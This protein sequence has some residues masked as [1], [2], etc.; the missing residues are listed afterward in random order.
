MSGVR[1]G[2][3]QA[4]VL[5]EV[6][7]PARHGG[8]ELLGELGHLGE[9][10]GELPLADHLD[11]DRGL[12][13]DGRGA[14]TVVEEGDLTDVGA[15]APLGDDPPAL[16]DLDLTVEHD[17]ELVPGLALLGEHGARRLLEVGGQL[18]DQ[19]EL[20][21]REPGEQRDVRELLVDPF[22]AIHDHS[23]SCRCRSLPQI[24]RRARAARDVDSGR[25]DL[26]RH[27]AR[28]VQHAHVGVLPG[29][30][31]VVGVA[32]RGR[33]R[34]PAWSSVAATRC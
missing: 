2:S 30:R 3:G 10:A 6:G 23:S 31:D 15:G 26:A 16:A 4:C 21:L 11:R 9:Q 1:R 27:P 18:R 14:G 33:G 22:V 8:E 13:H 32:A 12:G 7:E 34:A 5:V 29:R 25:V 17:D 19:P 24:G 20:L 28:E